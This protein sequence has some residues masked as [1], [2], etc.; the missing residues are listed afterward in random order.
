MNDGPIV[1]A[2]DGT[3]LGRLAIEQA[4]NLLRT[5]R[6]LIVVCVWQ[7]FDVGF[8]PADG[9]SLNAEHAPA[10][11]AAA[12]ATAERG[13]ELARGLGFQAQAVERE[14][15]PIWKGI[16]EVAEERDAAAIV[17]CAHCHGRFGGLLSGSVTSSI[18][19]H[20]ER[21]VIIAHPR[22]NGEKPDVEIHEPVAEDRQP[23]AEA[24][25][26]DSGA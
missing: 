7:P 21:T 1:I 12:L 22:S 16:A 20:T 3:D 14:A 9:S 26:A 18:T 6:L 5:A 23:D 2:F 17:L 25:H 8:V 24:Q 13:A 10:V 4:E 15:A 19:A 11:R